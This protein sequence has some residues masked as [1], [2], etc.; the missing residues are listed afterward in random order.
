MEP[1]KLSASITRIE[2]VIASTRLLLTRRFNWLMMAIVACGTF[3]FAWSEREST[4]AFDAGIAL[5]VAIA[6]ALLAQLVSVLLNGFGVLLLANHRGGGLGPHDFSISQAGVTE[7]TAFNDLRFT[8]AGIREVI[9]LRNHL[10]LTI[11]G[12]SGMM[13]PRRAFASDTEFESWS[14]R[15][16]A[17]SRDAKTQQ[18]GSN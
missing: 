5:F 11:T 2:F 12:H 10:L 18:A 1:V 3:S 17:W 9:K 15:A 16:L 7:K 6:V 4:S 14:A 8:W 13:I